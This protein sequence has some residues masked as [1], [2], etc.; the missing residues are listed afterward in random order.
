MALERAARAADSTSGTHSGH[1]D[2]K[3]PVGILPYLL[4]GSPLMDRGIGGIDE[5]SEYHSAGSGVTELLRLAD[6]AFHA[7]GARCKHQFRTQGLKQAPALLAHGLG[8]R[9]DYP[10]TF[11]CADPGKPDPC[12]A[13][14][15]LYDGRTLA[16]DAF[17]LGVLYHG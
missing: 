8:H 1:E 14:G 13:A 4:A 11:G 6:G 15:R 10:V 12:I 9:Q 16:Q 3:L 17:L 7:L 2:V 5:L